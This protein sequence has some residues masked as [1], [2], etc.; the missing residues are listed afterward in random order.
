MMPAMSDPRQVGL[1]SADLMFQSRLDS[2]VSRHR[3][4]LA[5]S[6]S[7]FLPPES[8][9]VFV[10]LNSATEVRLELIARLRQRQPRTVIIGF[11]GH[12]DR[13]TRR[14][15]MARGANQVVTNGALATV[16]DRLLGSVSKD[17]AVP[18]ER[19]VDGGET[20]SIETPQ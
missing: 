16:C 8:D 13:E 18:L 9:P 4:R 3:A 5:V 20:D 6:T 7:D 15:A 17:S 19:A 11:C 2:P 1:I 14:Q 10:D 12:D